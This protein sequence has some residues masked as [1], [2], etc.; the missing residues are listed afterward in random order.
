L[1]AESKDYRFVLLCFLFILK[2]A[3]AQNLS[4]I[5]L[6]VF[7]EIRSNLHHNMGID[8]GGGGQI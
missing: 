6:C 7:I 4:E 5:K 8:G 1:P 2:I 3:P